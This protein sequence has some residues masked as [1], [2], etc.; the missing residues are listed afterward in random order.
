MQV[1]YAKP[2]PRWVKSLW[3]VFALPMLLFISLPLISL[4]VRTSPQ[5]LL[6][7]LQL[8]QVQQAV[9]L[10]LLTSTVTTVISIILGTPV[11]YL[12]ARHR[13]R[14]YRVIDT[15]VDLPTVLPPAVAGVALLMAFGRRGVF[16]VLFADAGFAIP[17]T[18]IAVVM[19]Q[20]FIAAPLYIKAATIGFTNVNCELKQAASLD[21]A[22]KPQVFRYIMVPMSWKALVNGSVMTWAR[23]MGEFGATMIFAGNFPGRTQTMPLAIYIGFEI[24]MNVALTLSIIL[25]G[26]SF[27]TLVIVKGILHRQYEDVVE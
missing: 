20:T 22:S 24:D 9:I 4:F 2:L 12:L 7:G 6:L 13:F 15:L 3:V 25:I 16:G 5:N 11:A 21:G 27:L 14:F 23:A 1:S 26:F 8:N 18:L 17:F 19:A 10:S